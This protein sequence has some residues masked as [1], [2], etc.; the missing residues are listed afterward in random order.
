VSWSAV[1]LGW[2]VGMGVA[3]LLIWWWFACPGA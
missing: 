2:L 1:L 3:L